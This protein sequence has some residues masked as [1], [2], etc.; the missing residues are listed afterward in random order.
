MSIKSKIF[1]ISIDRIK[2][3]YI[4]NPYLKLSLAQSAQDYPKYKAINEPEEN[5]ELKFISKKRGRKNKVSEEQKNINLNEK[6]IHN[7]FSNDNIKRR[8]KAL[9]HNY[10][11]NLLNDLMSQYLKDNTKKFVKINSKI[12]KDIGIEYN[13]KLLD[14]KIKDVIVEVSDKYQNKENNKEC[15]K[16]IESE[17][18]NE[19][20]IKILNMSYKELYTNYY[21]KSVNT[22]D[23]NSFEEHKK[24]LVK[25]CGKEYVE[26]FIENA[27]QFV[28]FFTFGKNR[29]SRKAKKIEFNCHNSEND[30]LETVNTTE[31]SNSGSVNNYNTFKNMVSASTQ[32]D[33][34]DINAK[35]IAFF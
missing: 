14:K 17:K 4:F 30:N 2:D 35:I 23:L 5:K 1:D 24:K 31:L 18:N 10:I 21:L 26:R 29:K 16:Y 12:T 22:S 9:F 8:L 3:P 13:R 15:I 11:I 19:N 32:T 6:K 27:E 25:E 20:I 28:D 34:Q 7:K 33:I